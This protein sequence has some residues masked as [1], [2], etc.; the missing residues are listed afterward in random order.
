MTDFDIESRIS[1]LFCSENAKNSA[2]ERDSFWFKAIDVQAG[3]TALSRPGMSVAVMSGDYEREDS[4][5]TVKVTS[6]IVIT[7]VVKN[8]A[9]E[10]ERRR[11]LHPCVQYVVWKLQGN[12]LGLDISPLN[13]KNWRDVTA[14]EHLAVSLLVAEIEFETAYTITPET[15]EAC[16]RNLLA[17]W[18]SFK[19][20]EEPFEEL[21]TSKVIFNN[22]ET[23]WH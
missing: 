19:S 23:E 3:I 10:K 9:S 13:V 1:E 18:S 5:D 16:N 15:E 21:T 7:L 2:N 6:K 17:I 4:T 12:D 14:S 11:I 22:G 8:V 20:E